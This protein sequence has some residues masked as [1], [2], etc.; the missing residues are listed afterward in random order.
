MRGKKE[1]GQVKR[2][3]E[4]AEICALQLPCKLTVQGRPVEGS[5]QHRDAETRDGVSRA[6]LEA[7]CKSCELKKKNYLTCSPADPHS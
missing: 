3:L 4:G 6:R 7:A 2:V 1:E 5:G